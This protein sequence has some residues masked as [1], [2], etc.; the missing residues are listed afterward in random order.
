MLKDWNINQVSIDAKEFLESESNC[1]MCNRVRASFKFREVKVRWNLFNDLP[2]FKPIYN[3]APHRP[4]ADALAIIR[5]EAGNEGR[6]MYWPLI[7]FYEKT[8]RLTYSTMNARIERLRDAKTYKRL[9]DRRR[10]IIPVDGF[11]EFQGEK[12]PKTPWFFYLR[13]KEPLRSLDCGTLGKNLT[14]IS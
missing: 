5:T 8:T 14:V 10:C 11:Y 2:Q 6:L 13:S 7:P 3:I 4:D 9:L 12:P 1:P